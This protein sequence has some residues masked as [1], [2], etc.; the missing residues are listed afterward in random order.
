M[1]LT[2]KVSFKST[3]RSERIIVP[4]LIRWQ[5]KLETSQI[6]KVTVNI[7]G[8]WS[9]KECYLTRMRKD[10]HIAIPR[11]VQTRLKRE[12]PNLEGYDMDITIEPA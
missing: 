11:I 7:A 8:Q 12:E 5:H 10:G 9:N 6:L 3:L 4:K 2:G 1:T